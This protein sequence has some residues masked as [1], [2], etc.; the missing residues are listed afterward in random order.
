MTFVTKPGRRDEM[1][2]ILQE[3]WKL[4][5]H[6][7]TYRIY[8]PITGPFHVIHQEIEFEDFEARDKFWAE[9]TSKPG[10][11]PLMEKWHESSDD[12]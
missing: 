3:L 1:V 4:W 9:G 7:P 10:F 8:L 2:Q 5:D 6:P 12:G 11:A